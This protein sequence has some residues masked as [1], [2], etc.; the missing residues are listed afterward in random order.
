MLRFPRRFRSPIARLFK[1]AS[2]TA[3]L[4]GS[5]PSDLGPRQLQFCFLAAD[6]STVHSVADKHL[7]E[8]GQTVARGDNLATMGSTGRST[9]PHVHFEVLFKGR[10]VNPLSYIGR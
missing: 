1:G 9:G 4:H 10:P 8:V 2:D 3:A 5:F 6:R 7:V